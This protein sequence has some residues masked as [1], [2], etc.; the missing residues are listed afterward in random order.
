MRV[1]IIELKTNRLIT[2][3]PVVLHG[4]NYQPSEKE[5][6]DT[7]WNCAVEDKSVDPARREEYRF[8]LHGDSS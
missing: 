5:Y 1:R 4:A 6:F 3:I 2:E 7:G 8:E